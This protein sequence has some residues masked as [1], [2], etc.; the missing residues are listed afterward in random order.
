MVRLLY[1]PSPYYQPQVGE[2]GLVLNTFGGNLTSEVFCVMFTA[3]GMKRSRPQSTVY[4]SIF[5]PVD[6]L[7]LTIYTKRTRGCPR[8]NENEFLLKC[9]GHI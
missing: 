2:R 4:A 8:K 6:N 3:T 9:S 1:F 7:Q 5:E